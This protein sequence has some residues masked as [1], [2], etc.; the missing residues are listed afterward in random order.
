MVVGGFCVKGGGLFGMAHIDHCR[1]YVV[2]NFHQL[3][4]IFSL[5][6]S[7]C[8]HHGHVVAHIAHLAIGKDGMRRLVHRLA[9]GVG[10]EPAARQAIDL[11]IDDIR[12]V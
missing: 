1:Q 2:F 8:Y 5:L 10:N 4:S 6:Q 11:G 12:A 3:G 9:A 7:F